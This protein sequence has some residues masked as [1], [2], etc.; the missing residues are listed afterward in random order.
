MGGLGEVVL[1]AGTEAVLRP[2]QSRKLEIEGGDGFGGSL[3][4]ASD[5]R[6]RL[7]RWGGGGAH[8]GAPV[9]RTSPAAAR[10]H[11]A[12]LGGSLT[13][14]TF[15]LV[16]EHVLSLHHIHCSGGAHEQAESTGRAQILAM[17]RR[18]CVKKARIAPCCA[19][20]EGRAFGAAL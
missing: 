14:Q 10:S 8:A 5:R 7:R 2:A 20:D 13:E 3:G 11:P 12:Q 16:V 17:T 15:R 4:E 6:D 1:V 9:T 19:K 18:C